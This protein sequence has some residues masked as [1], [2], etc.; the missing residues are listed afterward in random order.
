MVNIGEASQSAQR[1]QKTAPLPTLFIGEYLAAVTEGKRVAIPK[2]FREQFGSKLLV[3]TRGYE[4]CMVIVARS[5]FAQ[6]LEGI[7]N[8]PFISADKRETSRFLLSGAHEIE[9]DAQGRVILPESLVQ[10]ASISG[11]DVVFIGVG[12]WVEL[13]DKDAWQQYQKRLTQESV[14]I[15]DRLLGNVQA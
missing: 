8:V 12:N 14:T 13:W 2:R 10:Y 3:I 4:G 15:A 6:L 7:T 1:R 11:N 5:Q 9:P